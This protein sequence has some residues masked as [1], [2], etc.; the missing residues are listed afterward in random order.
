MVLGDPLGDREAE[1]GAPGGRAGRP[2]EAVEHALAV[3][4]PHTGAGI[5]DGDARGIGG[6]AD[7]HAHRA[8]SRTVPDRVVHQD[9]H[10][11]AQAGRVAHRRCRLRVYLDTHSGG[12][13]R[14]RQRG[15]S[16]GR[17][18]VEMERHALEADRAG[19]G[20]GKQ[21]QILDEAGQVLDLRIDVGERVTDLTD[22]LRGVPPKELHR[23]TDDRQRRSQLVAG[24]CGELALPPQR[25]ALRDEGFADGHERPARVEGAAR[26][27]HEDQALERPDF[28]GPIL[29]DLDVE[30]AL[31]PLG[32]DG[33]LANRDDGRSPAGERRN[34]DRRHADVATGRAG[35]LRGLE[36]RQPTRDRE[37]AGPDCVAVG[38]DHDRECARAG[39]ED[40]V[41]GRVGRRRRAA[42]DEGDDIGG[43]VVQRREAARLEG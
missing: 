28:G 20:A 31:G 35:R 32:R 29:D 13:G 27:E 14:L 23:A 42:P 17:H 15:G 33:E 6:R 16:I 40:D 4:R 36:I 19:V 3:L 8:P 41:D 24:I 10:E 9:H 11:L 12:R 37:L 1:P 38:R 30:V 5:L 39:A 43:T 21:Q 34:G 25:E 18:V 7:E 26:D 2:P 22:G